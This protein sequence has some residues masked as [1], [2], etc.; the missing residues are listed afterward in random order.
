MNGDRPRG[1]RHPDWPEMI[2]L[3]DYGYLDCTHAEDGGEVDVW[4]DRLTQRR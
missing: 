3:L 2:Y 4:L 1:S